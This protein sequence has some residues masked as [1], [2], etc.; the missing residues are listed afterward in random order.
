MAKFY[1]ESGPN[2]LVVVQARDFIDAIMKSIELFE[3]EREL[4][5]ADVI[6]V[7]QRGFVWQREGHEL[8]GDEFVLPTELVLGSPC[9]DQ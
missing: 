9:E 4:Q 7:N 5:M 2:F 6:V 1:V 8:N 3:P